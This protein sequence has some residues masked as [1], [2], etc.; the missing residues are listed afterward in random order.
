MGACP[1]CHKLIVPS[2]RSILEGWVRCD[3][4]GEDRYRVPGYMVKVS[5]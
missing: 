2:R 1:R 4:D 3:C 5:R